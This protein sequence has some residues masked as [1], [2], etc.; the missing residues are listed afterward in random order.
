MRYWEIIFFTDPVFKRC[1]LRLRESLKKIKGSRFWELCSRSRKIWRLEFDNENN[2]ISIEEK[3]EI[4]KSNYAVVG[5]YFYPNSVVEIS[6]NVKKSSE[7]LEITSVN[8]HYLSS[9]NLKLQV[10]SR[11]FIG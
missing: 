3:P 8:Q 1:Y 9:K 4:A 10:L 11:G 7:E 2:V 5:L 6:K